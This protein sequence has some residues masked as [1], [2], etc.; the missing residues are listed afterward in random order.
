MTNLPLLITCPH[1]CCHIQFC[2]AKPT[3][4]V[5][6]RKGELITGGMCKKALGACE[7]GLVHITWLEHGPDETR[8][9]I[10]NIQRT[11]N[12]WLLQIGMSIGIGDTVAD[13]PTM[14]VINRI[15]ETAK[16]DVRRII[17]DFQVGGEERRRGEER[18]ESGSSPPSRRRRGTLLSLVMASWIM[19]V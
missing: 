2:H 10:N 13:G 5:L 1:A 19:H 9:L 7:G 15:I 17:E 16:N 3:T 14:A 12:H 6:I 11:V 4:Q 8:R 18:R